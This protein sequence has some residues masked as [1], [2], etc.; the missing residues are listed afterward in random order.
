MSFSNRM[1]I[2]I[3][4]GYF[5]TFMK[6]WFYLEEASLHHESILQWQASSVRTEG[7]SV[8]M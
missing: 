7:H 6:K 2:V 3:A 1:I 4:Q 8:L 5:F